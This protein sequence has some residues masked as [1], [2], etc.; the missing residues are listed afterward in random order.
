MANDASGKGNHGTLVNFIGDD[1]QWVT[2]QTGGALMFDGIVDYIEVPDNASIGANLTNAFTVAAWFKSN[3]PLTV[4][5]GTYRMFEKGDNIFIL[6]GDGNTNSLGNGGMNLVVKRTNA[7]Y[8]ASINQALEAN[9]WYHIAGSFDGTNARVYLDG[10]IKGTKTVGGPIDDDMLPLRIGADDANKFFNGAMDDVR[11]WSRAL[12]DREIRNLNGLDLPDPPSITTQPQGASKYAGASISFSVEAK[13]QEPF[14]Y[15]WYKDGKAILGATN[16]SYVLAAVQPSDSGAYTVKVINALGEKE[17]VAA[18]LK[19]TAIT[20]IKTGQLAFWKFDET[21]GEVAKDSSGNNNDAQL[22]DFLDPAQTWVAGKVGGAL[23]FDGQMNR[24]S[25]A[26]SSK[27]DPGND[28]SFS[29]WLKPTTYGTVTSAGNYD[30]SEGH[31][32]RRIGQYDVYVLDNP[33]SVR[34]TLLVNGVN[35]P[36]TSLQLNEWQHFA[37]VIKNGM[38][39]FYKNGFPISDP[40]TVTL[41]SNVDTNLVLG[42]NESEVLPSSRLYQGLLDE[43]GI[44]A[45]PLTE[46]EVLSLAGKDSIGAPAVDTQSGSLTRLEDGSAE[47]MVLATGA[48]PV[49]YQWYLDGKA[50]SGATNNKLTI[51]K[52]TQANAGSYTVVISNA[53]GQVTSAPMKLT[54]D[55]IRDITTGLIG[56]WNMDETSGTTLKDSSGK[57]RNATL[58]NTS[59]MAGITGQINGALD[60]NGTDTFAVVPHNSELVLTDQAT[61]ALW[62]NPRGFGG[63]NGYG[64]IIRKGINYDMILLGSSQAPVFFGVNKAAYSGPNTSVELNTWQHF[65]FTFKK[66]V[67]QFYKN[68]QPLGNP[69][70]GTLA[71]GTTD[72]LVIGNYGADLSIARVFDGLMDDLG[73]WNRALRADEVL[74]I[75]NNG[76]VGKPLNTQLATTGP[77]ALQS[78]T[79]TSANKFELKFSSQNTG[80]TYILQKTASLVNPQWSDV[81]NVQFSDLGQDNMLATFDRPS[82]VTGFYRITLSQ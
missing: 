5:G 79:L 69:I 70:N 9:R 14:S 6:Q 62:V 4:N 43:V 1:T 22:L 45:R 10:R 63:G 38:V 7:V 52:I 72:A 56:Y 41:G 25:V 57:N 3:V 50:I 19:V 73:L 75:Y 59:A 78:F 68:G 48:R 11:I 64:R 29:M 36:Q 53:V 46:S 80:R 65:V 37:A 12:S 15:A 60:F 51:T 74:G 54:V 31:I 30:I 17:S 23:Q 26:S 82:E 13:G 40:V 67:V 47:F 55:V 21:S 81:A 61:I 66:G 16:A 24:A 58:Q 2:G 28:A 39:S 77:I 42:S 20:D 76:L 27:L 18:E 71:A 35:A 44:W 8:S 33:G 32:L 49:S 34:Q